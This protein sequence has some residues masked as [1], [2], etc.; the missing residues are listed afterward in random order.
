MK[1]IVHLKENN[2]ESQRIL[3]QN[4]KRLNN[5]CMKVHA[6]LLKGKVLSAFNFMSEIGAV[7]YRKRFAELIEAG[8]PVNSRSVGGGLKEW[9]YKD[10][11]I[12]DISNY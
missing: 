3:N 8:Y 6:T 4:R 9:F 5:I 10:E 1:D 2:I 7:E 11:F 12:N